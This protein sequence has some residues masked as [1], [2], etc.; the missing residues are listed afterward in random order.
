M[1]QLLALSLSLSLTLSLS[2]FLSLLLSFSGT[3]EGHTQGQF[4]S[5]QCCS[6]TFTVSCCDVSLTS[7]LVPSTSFKSHIFFFNCRAKRSCS[8]SSRSSPVSYRIL[9]QK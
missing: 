8:S 2:L 1:Q 6:N 3:R 5:Y 4:F 7:I 9:K